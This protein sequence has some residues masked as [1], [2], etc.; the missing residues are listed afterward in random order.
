MS[1]NMRRKNKFKKGTTLANGRSAK[2][3]RYV[4]HWYWQLNSE[5]WKALSMTARCLEME[6][7]ALFNGANNGE[8]FLSVR[9]AAKR[10]GVSPNTAAK[11]FRELEEKCFIIAKQRGH[12]DWKQRHATSWIL[13]EFEYNGKAAT[14]DFM[15]WKKEKIQTQKMTPS[16]AKFNTVTQKMLPRDALT[17]SIYDTV[18]TIN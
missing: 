8:I 6:L 2:Q 4:R 11:A 7:K 15:R 3:E 5:A 1:N 18:T 17:D 9:E 14:K 12:F 13:T 10:L 16:D